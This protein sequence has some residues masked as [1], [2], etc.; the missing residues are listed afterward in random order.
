MKYLT[1]NYVG[2]VELP[3][4]RI[5]LYDRLLGTEEWQHKD[6]LLNAEEKNYAGEGYPVDID[7]LIEHLQAL[8]A[9]GANF[10]EITHHDEGEGFALNGVEV[11]EATQDEVVLYQYE[12][13]QHERFKKDIETARAKLIELINHYDSLTWK[14][15]K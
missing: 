13:Q 11:R 8:K 2:E 9:A 3:D 1:F 6:L 5:E 14:T 7:K 12:Q 15:S 4:T 10:V